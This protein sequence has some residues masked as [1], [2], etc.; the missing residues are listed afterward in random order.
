MQKCDLKTSQDKARQ[1]YHRKKFICPTMHKSH[2]HSV[3]VESW[4]NENI[5][6][7]G[8]RHGLTLLQKMA[9]RPHHW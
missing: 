9:D 7:L 1:I 5:S 2:N 6:A 8:H 3:E 4:Q